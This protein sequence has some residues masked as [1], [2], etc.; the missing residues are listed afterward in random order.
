VKDAIGYGPSTESEQKAPKG[1]TI[2]LGALTWG[3]LFVEP[4]FEPS[5]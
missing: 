3:F 5:V 1:A 2:P 4:S